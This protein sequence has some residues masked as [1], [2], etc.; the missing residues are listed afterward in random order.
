MDLYIS[1]ESQI[2]FKSKKS[3]KQITLVVY[4]FPDPIG[5]SSHCIFRLERF[6]VLDENWIQ[7]RE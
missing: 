1:I 6:S 5:K 7:H 3:F 4:A 2:Y